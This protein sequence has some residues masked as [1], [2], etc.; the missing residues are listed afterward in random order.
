MFAS[1]FLDLRRNCITYET[2]SLSP[3]TTLK[4]KVLDNSRSILTMY[5]RNFPSMILLVSVFYFT[6][7]RIWKASRVEVNSRSEFE[8]I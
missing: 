5:A 6:M 8:T 7:F 3:D 2:L 4:N 1:I